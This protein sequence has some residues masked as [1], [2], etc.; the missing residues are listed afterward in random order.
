MFSR[1]ILYSEVCGENDPVT[2]GIELSMSDEKVCLSPTI[3]HVAIFSQAS[4][5]A[6]FIPC[7]NGAFAGDYV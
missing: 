1:F 2:V 5:F 4:L 7:K 6:M 3:K